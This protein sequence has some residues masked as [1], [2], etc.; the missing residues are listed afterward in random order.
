[1]SFTIQAP[2]P[3][4]KTTSLLPNP[5]F[6]NTQG[7]KSR[8]AS[9]LRSMNNKRYTYVKSLPDQTL[10]FQFLL[11]RAKSLE[12]R[13]FILTYFASPMKITTHE[14]EVWVVRLINDP[15]EF[16]A[17]RKA[18]P[19]REMVTINLTMRGTLLVA[20]GTDSCGN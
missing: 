3:A 9:I 20:S 11:T 5:Q 17:E 10:T 15:F 1:M 7:I 18:E 6:A 2:Y 4:L 16:T 8:L 13:A 19:A 12:L 14:N